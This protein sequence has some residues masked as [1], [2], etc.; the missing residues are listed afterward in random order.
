MSQQPHLEPLPGPP[1]YIP[2]RKPPLWRRP[3]MI[4]LAG[5]FLGAGIASTG[6][7]SGEEP[8]AA[9]SN[10][11]DPAAVAPVGSASP[12]PTMTVTATVTERATRTVTAP[13]PPGKTV[14]ASA[15]PG[16]TVTAP[17]APARTVT[18]PVPPVRTVTVRA[19]PAPAKTVTVTAKPAPAKTVTVTAKPR[20][21][22]VAPAKTAAEPASTISR[23]G[24]YLVGQDIKPGAYRSTGN[25]DCFWA[26]L[27]GTS[28][29]AGDVITS[30]IITG[31][32]TVTIERADEAFETTRCNDWKR[33]D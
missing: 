18:A 6:S 3:W 5:L 26:R 30:D 12:Q 1:I 25:N 22:A 10:G 8:A 33:I 24:V 17:A 31:S 9:S 32:G 14:T 20:A 2:P 19:K 28:G 27:K 23:D 13:A 16:K 11:N 21:T 7:D 29:T 4:G 15:P